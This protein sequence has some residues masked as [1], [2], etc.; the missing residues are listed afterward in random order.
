MRRAL[1]KHI[2]KMRYLRFY[3]PPPTLD[4]GAWL[5]E[6][7]MLDNSDAKRAQCKKRQRQRIK[8]H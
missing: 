5:S 2:R 7:T 1:A 6:A 8:V 3:R 4:S